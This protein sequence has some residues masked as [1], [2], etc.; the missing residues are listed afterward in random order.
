VPIEASGFANGSL[1]DAIEAA[2]EAID[3]AIDEPIAGFDEQNAGIEGSTAAEFSTEVT[4]IAW[5]ALLGSQFRQYADQFEVRWIEPSGR[6][7]LERSAKKRGDDM[8]GAVLQFGRKKPA[9]PGRW[10]LEL[11][12][13]DD[14]VSRQTFVIRQHPNRPL[15]PL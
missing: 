5:W 15:Q 11:M 7:A 9:A 14:T 2:S 10:T 12:L 6:V 3:V 1:S 8:I 13:E 4:R